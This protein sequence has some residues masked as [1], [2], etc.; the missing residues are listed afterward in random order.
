MTKIYYGKHG[1]IY[2][3]GKLLDEMVGQL[4]IGNESEFKPSKTKDA[5]QKSFSFTYSL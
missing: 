4:D 5:F 1:S 2:V 3:D